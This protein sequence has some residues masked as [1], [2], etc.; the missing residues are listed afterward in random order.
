MKKLK[1]ICFC[2]WC[3]V[4][5]LVGAV[6]SPQAAVLTVT[7]LAFVGP[8]TLRNQIAA[9]SPG[10][11]IQFAVTGKI[12]LGNSLLIPHTLYVQGP[13]PS[14]LTIDANGVDRAFVVSGNPVFISGMTISNGFVAGI[15]GTNGG[16]GQNGGTGAG[17]EGGAIL[18]TNSPGDILVL[19][20]CWVTANTLMGGNGG[21]GGTNPIGAA[22]SVTGGGGGYAW[23]GAIY[24][25]GHVTNINCT[26]SQN[27]AI[28][29]KG[30][31]GGLSMSGPGGTGGSGGGPA[32]GALSGFLNVDI[33]CT[34][35]GNS[36]SGGAGGNG[37]A[38]LAGA[39]GAGGQGNQGNDG[40]AINGFTSLTSCTVVSNS[41]FA[42]AGGL[43]GS[44]SPPGAD[45]ASGI[46]LAG[47]VFGETFSCFNTIGNTILADNYADTSYSNYYSAWTDDG[48]NFIGSADVIVCPFGPTTV[49]GSV[50][51]PIHPRLGPLAQ[52]G[53]GLPT[54]SPWPIVNPMIV[55]QGNSLGLTTDERG[56]PRPYHLGLPIPPGGDG[57]DIGAFELGSSDLGMGISKT[58]VVLSWPAWYGDLMVQSATSLQGS[59]WNYLSV[60]PYQ[61][62]SQLVVTNPMTNAMMFYRL[63]SP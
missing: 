58:N 12:I 32:G 19:S 15:N 45:G 18:D 1:F 56:A 34:F 25:V 43:G 40:G 53:S 49:I 46:G 2:K 14:L 35:S 52:N 13:G 7:S 63:I 3:A 39:G 28:A 27:R 8:G 5:A 55:D 50:P 31:D 47:G 48:Y 57:S 42:G 9:S 30:G 20:N 51:A 36:V 33:N 6:V 24:F 38:S 37:G 22:F 10:D 54:H 61:V 44:G 16:L 17:L 4:L 23:G 59:N 62:G 60:T 29:G 21:Q 26:F 41:A 11:T